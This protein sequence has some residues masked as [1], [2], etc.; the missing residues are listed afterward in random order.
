MTREI[1][2][3]EAVDCEEGANAAE[4]QSLA[5]LESIKPYVQA[6]WGGCG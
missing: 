5:A 2:F 3:S 1:E 4:T 6:S